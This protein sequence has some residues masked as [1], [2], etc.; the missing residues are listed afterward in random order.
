MNRMDKFLIYVHASYLLIHVLMHSSGN[1]YKMPSSLWS[2]EKFWATIKIPVAVLY[3]YI[4]TWSKSNCIADQVAQYVLRLQ[5]LVFDEVKVACQLMWNSRSQILTGPVQFTS[6]SRL[7]KLL[8]RQHKFFSFCGVTWPADMTL[9]VLT[10]RSESVDCKFVLTYKWKPSNYS[11]AM[12]STSVLWLCCKL[13]YHK[14]YSWSKWYML[15][16]EWLHHR[17]VWGLSTWL[18]LSV[19]GL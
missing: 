6:S 5:G 7:H 13:H 8:H 2:I 10:S 11:N 3:W 4:F 18:I 19:Y 12:G 15:C 17:Q 9:L 16:V 1:V 14:V